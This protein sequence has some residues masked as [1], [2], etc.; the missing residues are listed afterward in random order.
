MAEPQ[1]TR[2]EQQDRWVAQRAAREQE[3]Q[4]RQHARRRQDRR[5][6]LTVGALV[7][8]GAGVVVVVLL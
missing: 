3:L 1:E 8:L 4:A 5:R 7:L 2:Q 6:W